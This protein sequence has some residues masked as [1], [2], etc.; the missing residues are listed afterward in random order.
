MGARVG[1]EPTG[2]TPRGAGQVN[3]RSEQAK[4]S[5][6]REAFGLVGAAPRRG[7]REILPEMDDGIEQN[8]AY[9]TARTFDLQ[10]KR[11]IL[12]SD[13]R[14]L[15]PRFTPTGTQFASNP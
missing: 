7:A 13:I 8:P 3:H 4:L 9:G 1:E 15:T 6:R 10:D 14:D 12:L 2:R 11:G 5:P